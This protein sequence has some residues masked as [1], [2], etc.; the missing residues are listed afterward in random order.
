MRPHLTVVFL[1]FLLAIAMLC[2]PVRLRAG[3]SPSDAALAKHGLKRVGAVLALQAESEVHAKAED[4]RQLSRQLSYAVAQQRSTLSEKE[5]QATIKGLTEEINELK[6][7]SNNTTQV[8]NRIPKRRGYP[9]NSILAEEY[10]GLIAYRNQL[11]MEITHRQTIVNQL[12]SK[13]F[14]PKDRIKLDDEVRSRTEALHQ[15]TLELRKVVDGLRE[16]YAALQKDPQVK[17][18]LN[19]PEGPAGVKPKLGPSR[20]FLLD[21]KLLERLERATEEP[22]A[23]ATKAARP[24]R[25]SRHGIRAKHSAR[26]GDAASPF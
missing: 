4:V 8:M 18:W 3:E 23:S 17:H 5:Y 20:A 24:S 25:K 22:D 19:T 1:E 15:G 16:K 21:E 7:E 6:G 26:S 14:D 11:Q 2:A 10:Q 9:A 12:K 13:P